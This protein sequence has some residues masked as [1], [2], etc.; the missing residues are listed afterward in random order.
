MTAFF[1]KLNEFIIYHLITNQ[2]WLCHFKRS[3]A[4]IRMKIQKKKVRLFENLLL[5]S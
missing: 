4:F 1:L 2:K 5:H 3:L